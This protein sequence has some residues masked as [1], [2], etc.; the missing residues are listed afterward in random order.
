MLAKISADLTSAFLGDRH[1][2]Q[3]FLNC[4]Q[5]KYSVNWLLEVRRSPG[6]Q[7]TVSGGGGVPD[8]GPSPGLERSSHHRERARQHECRMA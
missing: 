2:P 3:G 1:F 8:G 7:G 5:K 4:F 6:L